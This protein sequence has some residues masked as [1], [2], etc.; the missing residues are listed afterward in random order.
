MRDY[1]NF[2][3]NGVHKQEVVPSAVHERPELLNQSYVDNAP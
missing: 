2:Q 1:T 3:D